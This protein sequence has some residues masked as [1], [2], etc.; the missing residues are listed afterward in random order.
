MASNVISI[1]API[2][3]WDAYNSLD[4]MPPNAAVILENFIPR[5]GAVDTRNGSFVFADTGT[6]LPVETVASLFTQNESRLLAASNGGLWDMTDTPSGASQQAVDELA[7]EGT[8]QSS[9]WQTSNFTE[10]DEEGVMIM[11]NG[12]DNPQKYEAPYTAIA[13][14][15]FLDG[16]GVSTDYTFIGVN[17]F[18]GR[19]YYWE[20]NDN[21]F[22]YT[23]AGAYQGEVNRFDLGSFV[24]NGGKLK[25]I[26]TW[27]QQDSGDG[28]DD[29]LVFIFS[30]GE[31]LVYQGD[32]PAGVGFFE[33]VGRYITAE[34]LSI[35]GVSKYGADTVIMTKD[36]YITLSTIIQQG[37]VSDVPQFSRL[38]SN[39]IRERTTIQ[40]NLYGWDCQLF[41]KQG[42]FLFNVP[43][44]S[45]TFDQH[46]M[47]TVTQRWCKFKGMNVNCFT[48]HNQRLFGGQKD[49]TILAM[50]EG[51][52]D[53]GEAILFDALPAFN[54]LG[55]S[56]NQ[57]FLSAAQVLTTHRNPELIELTGMSDFN[58]RALPELPIP[59]EKLQATWAINPAIPAS[60]VGSYWNEDY[61]AVQDS[62]ITTKG[63]QN[64]S[65]FG[66]AVSVRVRFKKRNSGVRWRSTSIRYNLAGAQ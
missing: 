30:T 37:R 53:K 12:V 27:T 47:N 60:Q 25:I 39:A 49:G 50:L 15:E 44:S 34:P 17:V 5:A 59:E 1:D 52:D 22:Y 16:E 63:W 6:G 35:R 45:S 58:I 32:D 4:N 8:F 26:T 31:I 9:R 29:F 38:I 62:P 21:S 54:Y 11:C 66:Y 28:R 24:Q 23:R 57:K 3:G 42:L 43:K 61:W 55:D 36:G 65:A 51:S 33:Q 41:A 2:E 7:P 40:G 13:K 64:V 46:V 20:D 48:V 19:C 14:I 56:G 10:G 18:K